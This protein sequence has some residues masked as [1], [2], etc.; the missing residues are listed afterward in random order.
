MKSN[1]RERQKNRKNNKGQ[2]QTNHQPG[3]EPACEVVNTRAFQIFCKINDL[4]GLANAMETKDGTYRRNKSHRF[5][6]VL[7]LKRGN[8]TTHCRRASPPA[9][10]APCVDGNDLPRNDQTML[11]Q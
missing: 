9:S 5:G 2:T 4:N 11:A 7:W 10:L 1:R 6:K 3:S 8:R